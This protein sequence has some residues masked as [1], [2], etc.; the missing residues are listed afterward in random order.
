VLDNVALLAAYDAQLREEAETPAAEYVDRM[1]PLR[2]ATYP[3]G[4]GFIT[5]RQTEGIQ[6]LVA[7]ALAHFSEQPAIKKVE[8]KT[9]GHDC[10]PGLHHALLANGFVEQERESIMLGEAA[11]LAIDVDLP[12]GVSVHRIT[13]V[14]DIRTMCAV[15]DEAFG[16]P[17]SQDRLQAILRRQALDDGMEIWVVEV[18]GSIVG[19]GRLESVAGSRF[20]GIWGGAVL[21]QW[22]GRGLYRALTAARARSAL[23]MGKSLIHS[24]SNEYSRPVLERAGLIRVSTT[25]A[26]LWQRAANVHDAGREDAAADRRG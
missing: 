23:R 19:G 2:L 8:W 15:T 21:P 3:P 16:D 26:Y 20:A 10:V 14:A 18:D 11:R 6:H 17:F 9:R 4:R 24:D 7:A 1:G 12:E 5:Y 13:Q 25:T 22:R